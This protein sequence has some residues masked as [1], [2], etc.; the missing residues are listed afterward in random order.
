MAA[1]IARHNG[2]AVILGL[3]DWNG[4]P[5]APGAIVVV[6]DQNEAVLAAV[7]AGDLELDPTLG[8]HY[9]APPTERRVRPTP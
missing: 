7:A 1:R 3:L 5:I 8:R 2:A 4:Q 6:D 9:T